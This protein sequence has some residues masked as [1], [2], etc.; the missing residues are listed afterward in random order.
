M[1]SGVG[2]VPIPGFGEDFTD[3]CPFGQFTF[4]F[5]KSAWSELDTERWYWLADAA[6]WISDYIL[7]DE[8]LGAVLWK[9]VFLNPAFDAIQEFQAMLPTLIETVAGC[10]GD[11][12]L[13]YG[14]YACFSAGDHPDPT[15][16]EKIESI[17]SKRFPDPEAVIESPEDWVCHRPTVVTQ[18]VVE[19]SSGN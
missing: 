18:C 19:T 13:A 17:L 10:T 9:Q 11:K 15:A 7:Y 14:L 3:F 4:A 1:E 2:F 16:A 12:L 8:A 6:S 5:L